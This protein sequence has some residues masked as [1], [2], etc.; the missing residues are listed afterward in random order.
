[1]RVLGNPEEGFS[2]KW[3]GKGPAWELLRGDT[4]SEFGKVGSAYVLSDLFFSIVF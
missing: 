3:W 2:R 1:M 4:R